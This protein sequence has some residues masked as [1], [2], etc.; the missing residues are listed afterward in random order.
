MRCVSSLHPLYRPGLL[1]LVQ[2]FFHPRKLEILVARGRQRLSG[3]REVP[4]PKLLHIPQ[5]K[6]AGSSSRD[7]KANDGSEGKDKVAK[8]V[9]TLPSSTEI[10]AEDKKFRLFVVAL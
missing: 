5:G 6:D 3:D 1:Y 2:K 7:D 4:V 8:S 9:D 10:T